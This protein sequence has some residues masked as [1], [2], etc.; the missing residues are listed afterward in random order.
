[1]NAAIRQTGGHTP[2]L[3][4]EVIAA[5]HPRAGAV[6]VDGTLGAGGYSRALLEAADCTVWG[7]DRDPDAIARTADMRDAYGDRFH[8]LHGRFG[9]MRDLL[10]AQGVTQVDGVTLDL[11]A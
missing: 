6:F 3:L 10:A 4:A 5:L 9:D 8:A 1:M 11:G 2:V 7:I